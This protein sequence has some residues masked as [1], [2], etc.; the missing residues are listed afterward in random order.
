MIAR[1][2]AAASMAFDLPMGLGHADVQ[3]DLVDARD[4]MTLP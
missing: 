2:P 1:S 4:L 3:D